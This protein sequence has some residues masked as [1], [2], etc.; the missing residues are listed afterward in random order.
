MKQF[1]S[2]F[3]VLFTSTAVL[4]ADSIMLTNGKQVDG[5]ISSMDA[6]KLTIDSDGIAMTLNRSDIQAI[7][8]G[9]ANAPE[10]AKSTVET[11]QSSTVETAAAPQNV[12]I[13]AGT[14]LSVSIQNALGS[15][16]SQPGQAFN[17]LLVA[18]VRVGDTIVIPSGSLVKGTV[19]YADKAGRGVRKTPGGLGITL[20]SVTISGKEYPIQTRPVR[21]SAQQERGGIAKSAVK[22]AALGGI[23]GA[24]IDDAGDGAM[25]GAAVG[26]TKGFISK[27]GEIQIQVGSVIGFQLSHDTKL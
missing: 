2:V 9:S 19:L 26:A 7:E 16:R 20:K 21:Q 23:G 1:S 18:D 17:G 10:P 27:G 5:K 14:P 12:V 15:N 13:R 22:G 25:A 24:I 6:E 4:F 3:C 11:K 8:F